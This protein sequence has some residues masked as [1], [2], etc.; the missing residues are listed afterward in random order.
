MHTVRTRWERQARTV[1][2][3]RVRYQAGQD[4]VLIR[5]RSVWARWRIEK[6]IW[7]VRFH[8]LSF[9]S[10]G[11]GPLGLA[12]A[13][14]QRHNVWLAISWRLCTGYKRTLANAALIVLQLYLCSQLLHYYIL[15]SSLCFN[16]IIFSWWLAEVVVEAEE[17]SLTRSLQEVF[18]Q[19]W[20]DGVLGLFCAHYLG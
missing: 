15:K 6:T 16:F 20:N 14:W 5:Y 18:L 19:K 12:G 10:S 7:T 3:R 17:R 11:M 2:G 8:R 1:W 13:M 4:P 9:K